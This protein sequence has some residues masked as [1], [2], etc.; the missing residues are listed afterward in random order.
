I[1]ADRVFVKRSTAH[2]CI[3]PAGRITVERCLTICGVSVPSAIV[4]TLVTGGGITAVCGVGKE[5][6]VAYCRVPRAAGVFVQ[7]LIAIGRVV[8]ASRGKATGHCLE[9]GGGVVVPRRVFER[10]ITDAGVVVASVFKER[11]T[12]DGRIVIDILRAV[13]ECAR[14][15][16]R[17]TVAD[18]V[19][20]E[21]R[22]TDSRV[23]AASRVE[24]E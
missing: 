15:D 9:T 12:T 7:R 16:S 21:R 11:V 3:R 22:I 17:V 13:A 8:A 18:S 1:G 6:L 19:V 4:K 5:C 10:L 2:G 23:V 24:F 14:T 20:K